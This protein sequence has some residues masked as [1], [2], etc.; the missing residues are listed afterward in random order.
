MRRSFLPF[1]FLVTFI[2]VV[3]SPSSLIFASEEKNI[4][5][6]DVHPVNRWTRI[7]T[8]GTTVCANSLLNLS[9]TGD[10][11]SDYEGWRRDLRD[12]QGVIWMRFKV[13]TG[14][15]QGNSD[16]IYINF[17][18]TTGD[19]TRFYLFA[20]DFDD[21]GYTQSSYLYYY[22]ES[23]LV[24][25]LQLTDDERLH[26][27][28]WYKLRIDYDI[29]KSEMRWRMY[30]DN[31]TEVFDYKWQDV[32]TKRALLFS[33]TELEFDFRNRVTS[34]PIYSELL[35]DYVEAPFKEREW[36]QVDT[37]VDPQWLS[38]EWN[39]AWAEDDID[40]TSGYTL[41]VPYFDAV[42]GVMRVELPN[43]DHATFTT[44][45]DIIAIQFLVYAVDSD[46]GTLTEAISMQLATYEDAGGDNSD[47]EVELDN[48]HVKTLGAI[49]DTSAD[50]SECTFS[51]ASL[52]DRSVLSLQL[53]VEFDDMDQQRFYGEVA[54]S[55]VSAMA[56]SEFLLRVNYICDLDKNT[57]IMAA[58]TSFSLIERDIFSDVGNFIDDVIGVGQGLLKGG[59][60]IFVALFRWLGELLGTVFRAVGD[61]LKTAI[62]ATTVAITAMQSA[63]DT[64]ITAVQTSVD[65]LVAHIQ[66]IGEDVIDYLITV[67]QD[68]LDAILVA[69]KN[70]IDAITLVFFTGWNAANL[71][72]ILGVLDKF[73]SNAVTTIAKIPQGIDDVLAYIDFHRPWMPVYIIIFFMGLPLLYTRSLSGWISIVIDRSM[74]LI[75]LP[76]LGKIPVPWGIFWMVPIF[77]LGWSA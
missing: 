60:D 49:T 1:L 55:D 16:G 43:D 35:I 9:D 37:P 67:A 2:L 20:K 46:D 65:A 17:R 73:L 23:A 54:L 77:A 22:Y 61:L 48:S 3:I 8:D 57:E 10:A 62:D 15:N 26:D 19:T 59:S 6:F 34:S 11:S 63:L 74:K 29:P 33:E 32:G 53:E 30:F 64:A 36:N 40:D 25:S 12:L 71:P 56:S 52:N 42:S 50:I 28:L 21:D 44:S 47:L 45:G 27:A 51:I 7:M 72:N 66:A 18:G 41:T 68:V 39:V 70:L 14:A 76:I 69:A 4:D 31:D 24:E 75:E 13:D 58:V 38:D 5:T